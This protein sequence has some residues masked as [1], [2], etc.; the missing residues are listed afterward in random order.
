MKELFTVLALFIA[1]SLFA[2]EKG[3]TLEEYRYLSKGYVY[4]LEMGLDAQKEGYLV[5]NLFQASNGSDLIGLYKIGVAAPR[6][7][8]VILNQE[9]DKAT[10][11]C[12]PNGS[13]DK[14]VKALVAGDQQNISTALKLDYQTAVNEYLF[15]AL[16][17][18]EMNTL[19][20]ATAPKHTPFSYQND[21]TLV[22]RS[23]DLEKYIEPAQ[24]L[25][26]STVSNK[27]A[28]SNKKVSKSSLHGD[29]ADRTIIKAEEVAV[30][31]R[32]RGV[33]AIKICVDAD[34]NVTSAKFTQ[35]GSTTFDSYLKKVAL[36]AAKNIKF[37]KRDQL[38]QCGI[39]SYKFY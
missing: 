33:V 14:R 22:S 16:A 27:K 17:N 29:I 26:A 25:E 32:K 8:L 23:A 19:S 39:V 35:R 1:A 36:N 10:Y 13:A 21:E 3:T 4:Q 9:A 38:E 24:K 28:I 37:A 30:N 6:A 31:T 2:Q 34:G 12:I 18:P 5:K 7:L 20:Q 11:V 15:A